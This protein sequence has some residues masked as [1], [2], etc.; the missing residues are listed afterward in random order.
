MSGRDFL[1]AYLARS[2]RTIGCYAVFDAQHLRGVGGIQALGTG[3]SP[4]ADNLLAIG[5]G[6]LERVA[7]VD[8]PLVFYRT[9][10]GSM[11]LTS[12]DLRA[13]A[14]AQAD[15]VERAFPI[16]S[17]EGLVAD[18]PANLFML[19]R[20][21]VR[22]FGAVVRRAG[23]IR[24][25]DVIAYLRF[26]ERSVRPLRPTAPYWRTLRFAAGALMR[27]VA[28]AR[29]TKAGTALPTPA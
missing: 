12:P 18:L 8:A 23:R 19:L 16:L 4:Y 2:L 15:L 24:G 25:R 1:R 28:A 13:Y 20:W 6:L 22:D 3:F 10:A 21:C 26:V 29:R 11:S 9:H 14:T 5:C 7:W 17:S 27:A